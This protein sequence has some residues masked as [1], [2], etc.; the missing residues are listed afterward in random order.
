MFSVPCYFSKLL[1]RS[2]C[3]QDGG[4]FRGTDAENGYTVPLANVEAGGVWAGPEIVGCRL[5]D[6]N[7]N[8]R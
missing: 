1:L 8:S 6:V 3:A 7:S 2:C 5:G 4:I